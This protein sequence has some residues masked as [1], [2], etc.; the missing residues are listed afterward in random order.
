MKSRLFRAAVSVAALAL[1]A[2]CDGQGSAGTP[3]DPTESGATTAAPNVT[4]HESAPESP[5][6][7]GLQVPP[8]ATQVGPLIRYRSA[9]LISVYQPELLAA[10]AQKDAEARDK[11]AAEADE[12]ATEG[13]PPT[14]TPT[15][16]PTPEARPSD[17]T[18]K[19]LD[20]PPKPDSTVSLMRIDGDP[21]DVVRRMLAQIAAR[22]PASTIV[23]NDLSAYCK[24]TLRRIT[25]CEMSA[26]GIT[27]DDRNLRI[28][29]DVDPGNIKT[30]TSGPSNLTRP[31]MVVTVEYVGE[32]RKGQLASEAGSL[33]GV[34]DTDSTD[35]KSG[36]IWPKMDEDAPS[37][38]P[39]LDGWIA[40][41]TA[42]IL[43]SGYHPDFAV[44]TFT[45]AVS[46]DQTAEQ[47]VESKRPKGKTITKDI[48]EDL[49]EVSTT[50]TTPTKGGGTAQATYVLSARGNYTILLDHPAAN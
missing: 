32:P 6:A 48:V 7:F 17:D 44:T 14:P 2:S 24:S 26:H 11:A 30:R 38:E 45:R 39:L 29:M 12:N 37:T 21:T 1:I 35:E 4:E 10:Q 9:R 33:D 47:F 18:F 36:L 20:D 3:A 49:N 23:T 43:L 22:L 46:A 15:P 50:Y 19:L 40:P 5:I 28:T 16:T 13:T 34:E 41:T 42:T 31:V 27:E 25:R 8:G